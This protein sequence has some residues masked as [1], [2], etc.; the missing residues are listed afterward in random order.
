MAAMDGYML[1]QQIRSREA[2]RS[3][4]H[5]T[6]QGRTMPAFSE[7]VLPAI[8]LTAY[9]GAFEQRKAIESGFQFT[10]QNL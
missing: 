6:D 8:A 5:L 4:A 10:S 2:L 7:A 9:A 3:H 1:M